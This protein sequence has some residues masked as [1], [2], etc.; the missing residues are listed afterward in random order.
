MARRQVPVDGAGPLL[1]LVYQ[2]KTH[3]DANLNDR[4]LKCLDGGK[5]QGETD[6]DTDK[7]I[8][9]Q[10]DAKRETDMNREGH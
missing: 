9:R 5:Y 8:E 6:T 3:C 7:D 1:P 10:T 2:P 4:I